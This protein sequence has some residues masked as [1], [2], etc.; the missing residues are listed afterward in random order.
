MTLY[1]LIGVISSVT[2]KLF[3]FDIMRVDSKQ[4]TLFSLD[5]LTNNSMH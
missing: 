1:A 2:A 5:V 3:V 4:A